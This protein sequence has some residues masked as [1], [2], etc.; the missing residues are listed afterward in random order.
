MTIILPDPPR[1][2]RSTD[3]PIANKGWYSKFG[4]VG[5]TLPDMKGSD[6]RRPQNNPHLR[7]TL[8]YMDRIFSYLQDNQIRVFRVSSD[9]VRYSTHPDY[10]HLNWSIQ[11]DEAQAELKLMGERARRLGLRLSFHPSQWT[12][13]SS[14]DNAITQRSIQDLQ[15][16]CE[17]LDALGMGLE[18]RV[19]IHVGGV[20][21]EREATQKRV[22]ARAKELPQIIKRRLAFEN[23]DVSWPTE[24]VLEICQE[25]DTP[26]ILDWHHHN[27]NS[28]VDWRDYYSE[29]NATWSGLPPK[30]H[31]SSPKDPLGSKQQQRAHAQYLDP[32]AMQDILIWLDQRDY[33]PDIMLE[34][35]MKNLALIKLRQDLGLTP[36]S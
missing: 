34:C 17:F 32:A 7:Y 5:V 9:A 15:W 20:Y 2:I 24:R 28:S 12:L 19:L 3:E 4:Y 33:R 1:G 29:I 25:S 27:M 30:C 31:F 13:L 35:K 36:P 8:G 10:P 23:D 18:S 22:I 26:M 14:K 21:G 6:A 16:Q 11:K